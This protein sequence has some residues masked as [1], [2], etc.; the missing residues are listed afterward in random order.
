MFVKINRDSEWVL[1]WGRD[2]VSILGWS[3]GSRSRYDLHT[4]SAHGSTAPLQLQDLRGT[5]APSK[6]VL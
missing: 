3:A 5:Y 4:Q 2:I 6:Q 1:F